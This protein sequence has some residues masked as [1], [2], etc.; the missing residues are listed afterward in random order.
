[1]FVVKIAPS[2]NVTYATRYGGSGGVAGFGAAFD[3]AGN[4]VVQ[5]IFDLTINFGIANLTSAGERDICTLRYTA[6]DVLYFTQR[7]GALNDDVSRD[8][9]INPCTGQALMTG[10]YE[11]D[12]LPIYVRRIPI[13]CVIRVHFLMTEH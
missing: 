12:P 3:E 1:M 5:G 11:S 13:S 6:A 4:Y 9:A 10:N 7:L 2:G 8:I